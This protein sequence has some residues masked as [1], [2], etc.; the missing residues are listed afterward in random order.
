MFCEKAILRLK[1]LDIDFNWLLI[2]CH[3]VVLG[4]VVVC[5]Q[6]IVGCKDIFNGQQGLI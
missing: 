1:F 5:N 4:I 6:A 3:I 2:K